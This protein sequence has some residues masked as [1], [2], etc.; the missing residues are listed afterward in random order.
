[1]EKIGYLTV[2]FIK[3]VIRGAPSTRSENRKFECVF[4]HKARRTMGRYGRSKNSKQGI[5]ITKVTAE[6]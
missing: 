3:Y 2:I 1:M 4:V 5:S 6:A